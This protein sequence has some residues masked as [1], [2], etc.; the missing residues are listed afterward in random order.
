MSK[1]TWIDLICFS[2][3]TPTPPRFIGAIRVFAAVFLERRVLPGISSWL[4]SILPVHSHAFFSKN[5]PDFFLLPV[6]AVSKTGSCVGALNKIGHPARRYRQLK[7]V[8]VLSAR[9][10]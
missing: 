6:L 5:P 8:P 4:I 2:L 10:I 3:P 9:G 1:K 7:Q